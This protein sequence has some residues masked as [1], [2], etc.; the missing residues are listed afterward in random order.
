MKVNIIPYEPEEKL[1]EELEPMKKSDFSIFAMNCLNECAQDH[2]LSKHLQT[3]TKAVETLYRQLYEKA[4]EL[5]AE[6]MFL[7]IT[8]EVE[9]DN[10]VHF[11]ALPKPLQDEKPKH[12]LD[13][14][15]L[16]K[17]LK[18]YL[19]AVSECGQTPPEMCI[20]PLLSVLAMCVQGKCKVKQHLNDFTHELTLYTLTIAPSGNRKSPALRYFLQ[21]VYD[22]QSNYND[23][24]ELERKQRATE[25]IY[26]ENKRKAALSGSKADLNA[27]KAVDK[28][29]EDLPPLKK[30]SLVI[31]DATVEAIAQAMNEQGEKIAV[32]DP[33]GGV[34]DTFAGMYN[35]GCAN[36]D[37]LLKAYDGEFTEI[38]RKSSETIT[39]RRPLLSIGLLTQP[40]KFQKF[41]NNREFLSK[42]FTN[43]FLFSI[44]RD[45]I[46]Y[47][48]NT[49]SIPYS[50]KEAYSLLIR[51]LLSMPASDIVI[52]HDKESQII[53]HDLHEYIQDQKKPG[54]LFEYNPSY[55]EKQLANA[56]KIAAI[57]HLCEHEPTEPITGRTAQATSDLMTWL[58]NQAVQ[59]FDY[60][61]EQDP[62]CRMANRII[63][64][65]YKNRKNHDFY[66]HRD[67]S[68]INIPIKDE[69]YL[70][71]M[72][73]LTECN[74]IRDYSGK[75]IT[76]RGYKARLNPIIKP[77]T[78]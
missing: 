22:Y 35:G 60:E 58:F 72:E 21:P 42:G 9:E 13:I 69:N 2:T 75:A 23:L 15:M 54:R 38:R 33:E 14:E 67:L 70:P 5:N 29:L 11:W 76:D 53:F 55:A 65:M 57:L 40:D 8:K 66:S 51:K 37:L 1:A 27:A 31:T 63:E 12:T 36:I 34:L 43:R 61:T 73:L 32:L 52:V 39:M 18:D 68:L 77:I 24:H 41:I 64:K 20:L 47:K 45:N 44:F 71:A 48:D 6:E 30:L 4:V 3:D 7:D 59:A 49:P 26:L 10:K 25:R 78:I 46:R 50:V 62:V 74:Y 56:L 16:P 28:E 17:V 19:K